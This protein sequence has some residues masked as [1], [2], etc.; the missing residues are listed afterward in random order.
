MNN[1]P[2]QAQA[3]KKA[4]NYLFQ[5]WINAFRDINSVFERFQTEPKPFLL[6]IA[7]M[8]SFLLTW[9]VY[10]PIHELLHVA[11]CVISGGVVEEVVLDRKYGA[12]FLSKLFPFIVPQSSGYAGRVSGFD[13][14]SDLGYLITVFFP[15]I[16][17]VFPGV[18][19]LIYSARVKNM[20]V[21]GMGMIVGLAPFISLTGDYFEIGTIITTKIWNSVLQGYPA[22]SI[23]AYWNLRS[24]DIFRLIS[25]ISAEP[26]LYGLPGV[27]GFFQVVAIVLSGFFLAILFSGWTYQIGRILAI[28]LENFVSAAALIDKRSEL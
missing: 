2:S 10:V 5:G 28:R 14:G 22:Q 3:S 21:S 23:E 16:L 18:W 17:T 15:Y 20:W 4:V 11:G 19:L 7:L 24:D 25:E 12:G 26:N 9:F 1:R 13:P 8:L 6:L 27:L